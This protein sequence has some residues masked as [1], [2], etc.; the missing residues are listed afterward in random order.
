VFSAATAEIVVALAA[1]DAAHAVLNLVRL[2]AMPAIASVEPL[3][4]ARRVHPPP[5]YQH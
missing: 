2:R 4:G 3:G 5:I 1:A